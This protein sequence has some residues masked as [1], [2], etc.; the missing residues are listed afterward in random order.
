MAN[1][2]KPKEVRF[3][4]DENGVEPFTV[5]LKRLKDTQGRRRIIKR[6]IRLEIGHFGDCKSVGDGLFELRMF[7]GPGYRAYF[8]EDGDQIVIILCGGDKGTQTKDIK[9]AKAYWK[10]YLNNE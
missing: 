5:W 10:E 1:V 4:Q 9:T 6:L 7:F 8:G 3:Y 2:I